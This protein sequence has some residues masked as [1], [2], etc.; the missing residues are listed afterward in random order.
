M[1][2]FHTHLILPPPLIFVNCK[3][4]ILL[5]KFVK[6]IVQLCMLNSESD[7]PTQGSNRVEKHIEK[8]QC[9]IKC[10]VVAFQPL[11]NNHNYDISTPKGDHI[12]LELKITIC[13]LKLTWHSG[14][15]WMHLLAT[16]NLGKG[17]HWA[18]I[19]RSVCIH[20]PT[21]SFFSFSSLKVTILC[22]VEQ[23]KSE[24]KLWRGLP[25]FVY[26]RWTPEFPF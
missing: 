22:T 24:K 17:D 21:L 10:I 19:G 5:N 8:S 16:M 11:L 4:F 2:P 9:L 3:S 14:M 7:K 12:L 20:V 13:S 15:T 18:C 1:R 6:C 26:C 25:G 23:P